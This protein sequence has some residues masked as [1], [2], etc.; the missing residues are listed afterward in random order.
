MIVAKKGFTSSKYIDMRLFL[1]EEGLI[2]ILDDMYNEIKMD[3]NG[4]SKAEYTV[5]SGDLK[6]NWTIYNNYK[7]AQIE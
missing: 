4:P 6:F 5:S 1:D 7:N 2:N 3:E